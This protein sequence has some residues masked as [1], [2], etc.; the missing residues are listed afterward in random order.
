MGKL[1]D[2]NE[3][4]GAWY[5]IRRGKG[6]NKG[7]LH[8]NLKIRLLREKIKICSFIKILL[9]YIRHLIS[10]TKKNF[11]IKGYL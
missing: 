6:I 7:K 5:R 8:Q 4:K 11:Y 3:N 10:A 2:A 9:I 1:I